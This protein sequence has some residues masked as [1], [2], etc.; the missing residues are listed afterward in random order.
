MSVF[1]TLM[2]SYTKVETIIIDSRAGIG[3]TRVL[4]YPRVHVR[5][6]GPSPDERTPLGKLRICSI[7][8]T[9]TQ[10]PASPFRGVP[11]S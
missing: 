7:R 2:P 11:E 8:L 9:G 1:G 3:G 10:V 6:A 4:G 5:L